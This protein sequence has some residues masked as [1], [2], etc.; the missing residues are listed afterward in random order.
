MQWTCLQIDEYLQ[1]NNEERFSIPTLRQLSLEKLN[2]WNEQIKSTNPL[3]D[4][5]SITDLLEDINNDDDEI[6]VEELTSENTNIEFTNSNQINIPWSMMNSLEAIYGEL[7]NKSSFSSN[8][9]GLLVPVDDDL[10]FSIYQALQRL[11]IKSNENIKP[12]IENQ[13]KKE[14]KKTNNNN[15]NQKWKLPSQKPSNSDINTN[16]IPSLKQI[17]NEEQ[18]AAKF[19]KPKQVFELIFFI[20]S[21]RK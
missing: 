9:H 17:M 12:V 4:T 7:P 14:N 13:R 16:N 11:I 15:N 21:I 19:Q 6:L 10:S 20:N 5:K 8:N 1:N 3:F 2:Q 18:Q